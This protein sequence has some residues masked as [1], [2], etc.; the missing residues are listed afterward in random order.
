MSEE[1]PRLPIVRQLSPGQIFRPWRGRSDLGLYL[2]AVSIPGFRS[3]ISPYG[4][5][6]SRVIASLCATQGWQV[7]SIPITVSEPPGRYRTPEESP[8]AERVRTAYAEFWTGMRGWYV[9]FEDPGR[10]HPHHLTINLRFA[11]D[12]FEIHDERTPEENTLLWYIIGANA[13]ARGN[14]RPRA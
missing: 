7:A 5:T 12:G 11:M 14:F 4:M 1:I 2:Y 9:L 6:T 10:S 8:T 13:A 3:T